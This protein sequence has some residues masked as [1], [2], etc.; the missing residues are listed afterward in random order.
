[1][2]CAPEN[3]PESLSTSPAPGPECVPRHVAI[4]M[5]GNGRWARRLG[6]SRRRG[7]SEGAESVRVIVRECARL[8]VEQLT[9]YAFSTEN[10]RRPRTEVRLLM[11][12][13]KRFLISERR[14][15]IE[16]NLRL[17]AI[18]RLAELPDE[19]RKE[20]RKSIE[21]CAPNTGMILRLALNYGGRQEILD[22]ARKM[23]LEARRDG[24]PP[25]DWTERDFTLALYDAEM[26]DPDLLIRT[27]GEKRL[28]NF[29]LWQTSYAELWFTKTCWPEFRAAHL[30]QALRAYAHRERRFGGLQGRRP[31]AHSVLLSGRERGAARRPD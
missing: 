2:Q 7:H 9:L 17:R 23:A 14:E 8:G 15:L 10:W 1:M 3:A 28:S 13:L 27:G 29:L 21:I 30:R 26:T 24:R 16:N 18:G 4:I 12:L 11:A 20:L 25:E 6:L 19:V 22:A 5:D 31:P